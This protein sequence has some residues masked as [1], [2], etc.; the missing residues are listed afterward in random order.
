MKEAC[1]VCWRLE[2]TEHMF[3]VKTYAGEK[4]VCKLCLRDHFNDKSKEAN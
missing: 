3:D 2:D 1:F 4:K